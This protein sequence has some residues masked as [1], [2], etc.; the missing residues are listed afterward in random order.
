MSKYILFLLKPDFF[1]GEDGPFFCP[2]NAAVE[3]LLKYAPELETK[4]DIRRVEFQ[5]P[6]PDIIAILGE[7]NQN[8]Q[9][10]SLT[11]QLAYLQMSK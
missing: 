5:R 3:G 4:L 1:D 9:C 8:R 7:E 2:H 11:N 6:K 10:L